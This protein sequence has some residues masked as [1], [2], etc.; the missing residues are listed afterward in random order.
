[1]RK[2]T[3]AERSQ[4]Q[5]STKQ[6]WVHAMAVNDKKERSKLKTTKGKQRP[7]VHKRQKNMPW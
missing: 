7:H 5:S 4:E 3:W 1:V 6:Q 2:S